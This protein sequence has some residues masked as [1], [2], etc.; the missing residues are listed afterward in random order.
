L[1]LGIY[2]SVRPERTNRKK[3]KAQSQKVH[4]SQTRVLLCSEEVPLWE[5]GF[6]IGFTHVS[7][8]EV[9]VDVTLLLMYSS[10]DQRQ[11]ESANFTLYRWILEY[12]FG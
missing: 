12:D 8:F 6:G 1:K 2:Y 7:G 4:L 11:L 9:G 3:E 10:V 5:Y